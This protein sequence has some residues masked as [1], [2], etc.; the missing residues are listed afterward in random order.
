MGNL[1][2]ILN[3]S[4]D[5]T[6]NPSSELGRK[7]EEIARLHLESLGMQVVMGNFRAPIGR[8]SNNAQV[9]GEIDLIAVEEGVLRFVEVKTRSV[10][11]VFPAETAVTARKRR[12]VSQTARV[13]RRI[14]GLRDMPF[15]FDVLT[16]V[17]TRGS[18]PSVS[19]LRDFWREPRRYSGPEHRFP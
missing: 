1:L 13:Y 11:G 6:S 12:R 16:V 18:R 5:S 4:N 19:H 14:F 7:G 3:Q 10:E 17:M 15:A 2:S 8:N 9:F